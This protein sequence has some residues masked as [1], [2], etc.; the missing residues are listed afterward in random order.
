MLIR[1]LKLEEGVTI[2][3]GRC[4]LKPGY[5]LVGGGSTQPPQSPQSSIESFHTIRSVR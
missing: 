3:K 4:V 1:R 2:S 5:G